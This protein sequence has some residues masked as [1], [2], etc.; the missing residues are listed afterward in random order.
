MLLDD[1]RMLMLSPEI[2]D[3]CVDKTCNENDLLSC[4]YRLKSENIGIDS[5]DELVK[6][7][8][9]NTSDQ[10]FSA[11]I[12]KPI[13]KQCV[14]SAENKS[15]KEIPKWFMNHCTYK[16]SDYDEQVAAQRLRR[17]W[18]IPETAVEKQ[19]ED[20]CN[21]SLKELTN[22][23]KNRKMRENKM[24]LA[25]KKKDTLIAKYSKKTDL[26]QSD[27]DYLLAEGVVVKTIDGKNEFI[28]TQ[29]K[30]LDLKWHNVNPAN[31]DANE[32]GMEYI[33]NCRDN[34]NEYLSGSDT[35]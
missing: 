30:L 6:I 24:K 17:R 15:E 25:D 32:W 19:L 35:E 33:K 16:G 7:L 18:S 13:L 34:P 8:K 22:D 5:V 10:K 28:K 29:D 2:Y 21:E 4:V 26:T 1:L 23:E 20:K 14:E 12:Q 3:K 27:K 11:D 9:L 31:V